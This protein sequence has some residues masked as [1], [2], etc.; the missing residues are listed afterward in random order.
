MH[1]AFSLFKYFPHGG[2]QRDLMKMVRECLSR[3]H[4]V[5]IYAGEWNAPLPELDVEVV[6]VP[7]R[8]AS[9]HVRYARFARWV[10]E[11]LAKQP[12]DLVVGLNKMPGLDAYYA[13]DSCYAEKAMTQRGPWY[14]WLPRYRHFINFERA[15]FE[16]EADTQILTIAEVDVPIF[17]KHYGT[18]AARFHPLPPG[19]D[20]DRAAA[21]DAAAVRK[22]FRA[23]F[24]IAGHDL[25]LLFLGSGFIKKGL[26]RALRGLAALPAELAARTRML[27][28]GNDNPAKFRRLAVRLGVGDQVRFFAGRD[29]IPRFLQGA[30]ALVLPAYDETAGMVILEAMIAGLPA[31]V[32]HN[33]GYAHYLAEADA[34]LVADHP[35][36]QADFNALLVELLTSPERARWR[37]N[38]LQWATNPEIYRMPV[39]A[40]DYFEEFASHSAASGGPS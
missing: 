12:V 23:E 33:C 24:E 26:D 16:P 21:A 22:A 8:A 7:V 2:I 27:V 6:Q 4:Q 38:G 25:V 34:G 1:I 37:D 5:R 17:R 29:D 19:I 15:V 39:A 20:A 14:R 30:D 18:P 32:S 3:G 40:V 28:V 13:G 10:R 36:Q 11:H 35:F 31:L 9:N